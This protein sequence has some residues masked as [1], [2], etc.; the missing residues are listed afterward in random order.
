MNNRIKSL[1]LSGDSLSLVKVVVAVIV[2]TEL[3]HAVNSI[4]LNLIMPTLS[5]ALNETKIKSWSIGGGHP[6]CFRYGN[7]IWD[8]LS[9]VI[10]LSLV[11]GLVRLG[12]KLLNKKLI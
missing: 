6:L 8:M 4:K 1:K 7:V 2:G 12:M 11:Y 3:F 5:N 9:V 10:F